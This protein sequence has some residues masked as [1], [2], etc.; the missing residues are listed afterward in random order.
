M[1]ANLETLLTWRENIELAPNGILFLCPHGDGW[2]KHPVAE[3]I[4]SHEAL[5]WAQDRGK[6][7]SIAYDH[8]AL[9][10]LEDDDVDD[11][12]E[13]HEFNA[14]YLHGVLQTV[15]NKWFPIPSDKAVYDVTAEEAQ[16]IALHIASEK[17]TVPREM[18]E[19]WLKELAKNI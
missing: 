3:V 18:F 19:R 7:L 6:S 17:L 15:P 14:C 11:D 8:R 12:E 1:V 2:R 4:Y 10:D 16:L 9:S 5:V 13:N